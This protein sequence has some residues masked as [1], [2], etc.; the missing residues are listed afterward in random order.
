[1]PVIV[2][3]LTDS[4]HPF[5]PSVRDGSSLQRAVADSQAIRPL[6]IFVLN[7]M[8]DKLGTERQLT[9][10]I[11]KSPIQTHITFGATDSYVQGVADGNIRPKNTDPSHIAKFYAPFSTVE[12]QKF[13]GVIVTGVNAK[14]RD[15]TREPIWPEVNRI[16]EW[17]KSNA[18]SSLF[19][20][21][22]AHAALRHFHDV[23]RHRSE[24]KTHG[25]F[26]HHTVKDTTGLLAGFSDRYPMPVSR[27]HEIRHQDLVMCPSLEIASVSK[28]AG[29][30]IV[31]ESE[32]YGDG[33]RRFPHRFYLLTHPEYDTRTL[34]EEYERDRA[35]NAST[36][37]P[38]NYFTNSDP[39]RPIVNTWR[40]T[41]QL[42]TEWVNAIYQATPKRLE[43]V[44][45]PHFFPGYGPTG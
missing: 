1:M 23:D 13:D 9:H 41:G 21:W 14:E 11:G 3:A 40:H 37:H 19:L 28:E 12:G 31:I 27:W 26:E 24:E 15:V 8:A 17:T 16:L 38:Q 35:L 30:G 45:R 18:T 22:G 4:R 32:A 43:E 10:W 42:Y 44:P 6:R 5:L 39:L 2:N 34:K 20:C 36:S 25:V 33:K 29:V 7:L